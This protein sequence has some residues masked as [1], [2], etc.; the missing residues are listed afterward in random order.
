M[1]TNFFNYDSFPF[2]YHRNEAF[3]ATLIFKVTT[4]GFHPDKKCF[5]VDRHVL[6]SPISNACN[7]SYFHTKNVLPCCIICYIQMYSYLII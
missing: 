1:I 4:I 3:P 2:H 7:R 5:K 6:K